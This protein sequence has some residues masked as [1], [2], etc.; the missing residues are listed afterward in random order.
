MWH[1]VRKAIKMF[2][3]AL[4]DFCEVV[5]GEHLRK[6]KNWKKK[7]KKKGPFPLLAF[8]VF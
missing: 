6:V 5:L 7:K 2:L 8:R 4:M 1:A 3:S